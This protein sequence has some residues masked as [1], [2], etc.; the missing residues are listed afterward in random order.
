MLL[1]RRNLSRDRLRLGLS[2]VS[3]GLAV[4]L[5]L[6]LGGYRAGIYRQTATYLDHAPGSV[7]IGEQ[8]VEDFLG[9]NSI[10]PAGALEAT[11]SRPGVGRVVPILS[12]SA[13]VEQHGR[14]EVAFL[15]GYDPAAGGGPWALSVGR[16]PAS[17]TEV[18]LDRVMA[19]EHGL[20]VGDRVAILDRTFT[21]TGLSDDTALW[22]GSLVFARTSA[23]QE[24]VRAP[25]ALSYLFVTPVAGVSAESLLAQLAVPGTSVLLKSEVV[26]ADQRLIARIY[27]AAIGLMTLIAF[28]V[29]VLVVGLVVY[30]ATVERRREYGAFK[31]IG[32]GNRTLYRI[33]AIQALVAGLAGAVLGTALAYLMGAALVAWRPQFPVAI[34]PSAILVALAASVSMAVLAALVPARAMSDL[35]PAEVFR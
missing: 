4:M 16:A 12:Q 26:V 7:V 22:I 20:H 17:D 29:G 6:L 32:A 21:I 8:G 1:A 3:V 14:K 23:V 10:L 28:L 5:I 18:V 31:A 11:R 19:R 35:A 15:I 24:L 25:G 9:T 34:E 2:V 30:T 33:V 13:I 27:D